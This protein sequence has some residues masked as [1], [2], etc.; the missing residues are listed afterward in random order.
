VAQL[1]QVAVLKLEFDCMLPMGTLIQV[2]P[3]VMISVVMEMISVELVQS[4]RYI[5]ET[6]PW[7]LMQMVIVLF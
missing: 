6:W 4:V 2:M 5:D 1:F 7:I 3:S